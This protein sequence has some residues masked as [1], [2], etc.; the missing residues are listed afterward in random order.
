MTDKRAVGVHNIE[1][2]QGRL[3]TMDNQLCDKTQSNRPIFVYSTESTTESEQP[4]VGYGTKL[5]IY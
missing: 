3:T 4:A 1:E 5:S 2:H